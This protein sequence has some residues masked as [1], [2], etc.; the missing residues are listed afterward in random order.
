MEGDRILFARQ[1][2]VEAAWA[3]VDPA[4]HAPTPCHSYRPG[5]WGPAEASALADSVGGWHD[6]R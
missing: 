6:P 3:V 5:T 1:D 2:E 4:L